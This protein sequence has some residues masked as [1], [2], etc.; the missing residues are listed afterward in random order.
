MSELVNVFPTEQSNSSYL[1][2]I[3]STLPNNVCNLMRYHFMLQLF[4]YIYFMFQVKPYGFKPKNKDLLKY[5]MVTKLGSG[6]RCVDDHLLNS[7]G[8][9]KP[10][11]E[12][13]N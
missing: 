1:R 6:P 7:D 3:V 10:K 13:I 4:K 11:V 9:L 2:G 8:T 12:S 5:I